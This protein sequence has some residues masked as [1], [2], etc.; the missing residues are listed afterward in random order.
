MNQPTPTA[1]NKPQLPSFA[2]LEASRQQ[3]QP[4]KYT[5]EVRTSNVQAMTQAPNTTY[6]EKSETHK[7]ITERVIANAPKKL[8]RSHKSILRNLSK[9]L[10]ANH[11]SIT[12]E[13][14]KDGCG[15]A[16]A[17]GNEYVRE[18]LNA[19]ADENPYGSAA[20][21]SGGGAVTALLKSY[22]KPF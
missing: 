2:E 11:P 10:E 1:A 4:P 16:G 9:W 7:E 19:P 15:T 21:A 20:A 13:T 6:M 8:S 3:P 17:Y 14:I 18:W 12:L 22:G 5:F